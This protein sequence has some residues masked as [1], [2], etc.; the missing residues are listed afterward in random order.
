MAHNE[1]LTTPAQE[2]HA[3]EAAA[4]EKHIERMRS[5]KE[6][7]GEIGIALSEIWAGIM[8]EEK[9]GGDS[10]EIGF[11]C[12][13][14]TYNIDFAVHTLS[15]DPNIEGI[16]QDTSCPTFLPRDRDG[17]E[18]AIASYIICI[19]GNYSKK[20]QYKFLGCG[21][22]QELLQ[23]SPQT[24]ARL[25]AELDIVPVVI[26][27]SEGGSLLSG[28]MIDPTLGVDELA[29]SLSRKCLSFFGPN[30][31]PRVQV[32][33]TNKV[34]VDLAS[35]A[36]LTALAQYEQSVNSSTWSAALK[37]SQALKQSRKKMAFFSATP[38]G[39][40][41]ALMRHALIRFYHLLGVDCTWWV[42]KPKPEVFRV[43]KTNHNILQG[44][45]APDERLTEER[46]QLI[47]DWIFS[48]ANRYWTRPG[49]PLAPRS[50]GGVD[51][52]FVDDPQMPAIVEIA[53]A[54]DPTR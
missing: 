21:L 45:A 47:K 23:L 17:Q 34:E 26:P 37:Y 44:V 15:V 52:V 4:P 33:F 11:A 22:S 14:G 48:N 53:K 18:K 46:Q 20:I 24:A 10:V 31:Q 50:Q 54:Q 2:K 40:G 19:V 12:H 30:S 6:K 7:K 27:H 43:T 5:I 28:R 36:Q 32:G 16:V 41:V 8:I 13:D 35:R 38:Q 1:H 29:D 25:W 3:F 51:C 39:G 49:G 42:P 9:C